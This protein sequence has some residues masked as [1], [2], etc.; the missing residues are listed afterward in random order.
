MYLNFSWKVFFL[1]GEEIF[2][3]KTVSRFPSNV[4][5]RLWRDVNTVGKS[6]S[7]TP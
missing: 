6:E 2:T 7:E 3:F 1:G 5:P 4:A